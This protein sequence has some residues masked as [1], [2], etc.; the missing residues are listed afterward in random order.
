MASTR[1]PDSQFIE[2]KY[3]QDIVGIAGYKQTH[4]V[5]CQTCANSKE[6]EGDQLLCGLFRNIEVDKFGL[7]PR[8]TKVYG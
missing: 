1:T 2:D 5:V 8:W 4:P 6:G 3:L 7:C